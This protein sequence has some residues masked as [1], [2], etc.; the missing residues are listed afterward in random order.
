MSIGAETARIEALPVSDWKEELAKIE[1]ETDRKAIRSNLLTIRELGKNARIAS[2]IRA[3][4]PHERPAA[5][6]SLN[7]KHDREAIR[8]LLRAQSK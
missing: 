8:A 2:R 6:L 1:N 3:M 4:P 7:E 5:L